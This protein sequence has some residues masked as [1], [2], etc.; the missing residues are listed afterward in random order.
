MHPHYG[1]YK[2]FKRAIVKNG[3]IKA[4]TRHLSLDSHLEHCM[5]LIPYLSRSNISF[6]FIPS[7]AA[8]EEYALSVKVSVSSLLQDTEWKRSFISNHTIAPE[9]DC[10][11]SYMLYGSHTMVSNHSVVVLESFDMKQERKF[12]LTSA[13]SSRLIGVIQS[14]VLVDQGRIL[15]ILDSLI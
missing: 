6:S 8:I 13:S 2:I 10:K 7:D 3:L 5:R 11:Y 9:I 1:N 15:H 14:D 4:L 12:F